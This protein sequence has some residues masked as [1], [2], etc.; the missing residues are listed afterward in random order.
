MLSR[1]FLVIYH[2]IIAR[3]IKTADELVRKSESHFQQKRLLSVEPWNLGELK[4]FSSM[5]S[6]LSNFILHSAADLLQRPG[7]GSSSSTLSVIIAAILSELSDYKI[8]PLYDISDSDAYAKVY[9]KLMASN[10]IAAR[11]VTQERYFLPLERLGCSSFGYQTEFAP[12]HKQFREKAEGSLKSIGLWS[13]LPSTARRQLSDTSTSLTLR[14]GEA[15]FGKQS[16]RWIDCL[17][18]HILLHDADDD[19]LD[20]KSLLRQL[21]NLKPLSQNVEAGSQHAFT[22][23][24]NQKDALGRTILHVACQRG[25]LKLAKELLDCGASPDTTTLFGSS[26]LHYACA[27]T[28]ES[29][30]AIC[31]LLTERLQD[32]NVKDIYEHSPMYYADKSGRIEK[33]EALLRTGKADTPEVGYTVL[34]DAVRNGNDALIRRLAN[35]GANHRYGHNRSLIM[36]AIQLRQLHSLKAV[37]EAY[38]HA[39][40]EDSDKMSPTPL[41]YAVTSRFFEG[42]EYL[43]SREDVDVNHQNCDGLCALHMAVTIPGG[44]HIV[45]L[46]AQ[47]SKIDKATKYFYG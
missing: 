13:T 9:K 30:A 17:G 38:P 44:E 3:A 28:S 22:E 46:L 10:N 21:I 6:S 18:R 16:F 45:R 23:L 27:S 14:E 5:L 34:I 19:V 33:I 43:V 42:V 25:F 40:N 31:F 7:S 2:S 29:D 39:V 26:P 35:A 24:V 8:R 36:D 4:Q 32:L 1:S 37:C 41:E 12:T 20:E 47:H 11:F 15:G